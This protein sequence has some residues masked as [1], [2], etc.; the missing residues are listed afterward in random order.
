M[1]SNL[2][3]LKQ[4]DNSQISGYI[5]Q[6]VSGSPGFVANDLDVSG[7][8][9]VSGNAEILS[10]LD[11]STGITVKNGPF[12]VSG[13]LKNLRSGAFD[14]GSISYPF[15]ELFLSSGINMQGGDTLNIVTSGSKRVL[16]LNDE[17][18]VAGAAEVAAQGATGYT[19][20]QGAAGAA[21]PRRRPRQSAQ[22]SASA[23]GRPEDGQRD[24][25]GKSSVLF[26]RVLSSECV[27]RSRLCCGASARR[28]WRRGGAV[29]AGR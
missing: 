29:A 6:V 15:Q 28:Y 7:S 25:P 2:I 21:Q 20:P 10:G 18:I 11:V 4:L 8:L 12:I 14:I 5:L 1:P 26:R 19:G 13:E 24:S 16:P 27:L 22:R 23:L 17:L 9:L 3:K